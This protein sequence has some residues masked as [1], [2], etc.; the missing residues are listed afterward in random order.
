MKIM[1]LY[2]AFIIAGTCIASEGIEQ[3]Q[4]HGRHGYAREQTDQNEKPRGFRGQGPA[5]AESESREYRPLERW[6]AS[7]K[8]EDPDEYERLENIR[9]TDPLAFREEIRERVREMRLF[10]RLR[11]QHPELHEFLREQPRNERRHMMRYLRGMHDDPNEAVSP[12]HRRSADEPEIKS[13]ESDIRRM[14]RDYRMEE[15]PGRRDMIRNGLKDE[16]ERLYDIR[17]AQQLERI[18]A[19]EE[20]LDQLKQ[21]LIRD[22]EKRDMHIES[23]LDE[24]LS[25]AP[26]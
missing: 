9:R 26:E 1:A 5:A 10:Q 16:I 6:M 8:E 3:V 25:P 13:V 21:D 7:L 18:K 17:E 15:D 12:R 20:R 2:L 22:R 23:F 4:G 24:L 11:R 14:V 19:M